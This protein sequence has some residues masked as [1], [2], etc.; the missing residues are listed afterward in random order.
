MRLSRLHRVGRLQRLPDGNERRHGGGRAWPE[1]HYLPFDGGTD[2]AYG[3]EGATGIE[4]G[5]DGWTQIIKVESRTVTAGTKV[6]TTV[7]DEIGNFP[8]QT[9]S[10]IYG[11]TSST[12]KVEGQHSVSGL[13]YSGACADTT[14]AGQQVFALTHKNTTTRR[15]DMWLVKDGATLETAGGT[16][17]QQEARHPRHYGIGAYL[18][19]QSGSHAAAGNI[20]AVQFIAFALVRGAVTEAELQAY[21]LSGD[22]RTVWNA[23]RLWAYHA[24][25]Q[26]SGSSIPN[27]GSSSVP[28]TLSGPVAGD[29]VAL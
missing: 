21:S 9:P 2:F 3:D 6:Y 10:Y 11:S 4:T 24:A 25:S 1:Q 8:R 23:S 7:Y 13:L 27:L 18:T 26:V 14:L 17:S 28:L 5:V 19:K 22:A 12:V 15:W 29:L 16:F 20:L